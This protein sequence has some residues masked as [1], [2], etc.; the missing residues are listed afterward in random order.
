MQGLF[1]G[2]ATFFIFLSLALMTPELVIAA[3][4]SEREMWWAI[5]VNWFPMLLLVGVWIY[6]MKN[7]KFTK[8]WGQSEE[9]N[10]HL[11]K[12]EQMLERIARALEKK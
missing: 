4:E 1:M 2:K 12:I 5:L 3:E 6:F 10:R 9:T 7:P 8:A 11:E